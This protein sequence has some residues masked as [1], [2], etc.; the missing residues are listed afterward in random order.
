MKEKSGNAYRKKAAI[1]I[2]AVFAL[3]AVGL[4][5]WGV[6]LRAELTEVKGENSK[7]SM[8]LGELDD[9]KRRLE[10]ELEEST[11]LAQIEDY[12]RY[13]LGMQPP[14]SGQ[15]VPIDTAGEDH[16]ELIS[17]SDDS[18]PDETTEDWISSL[19]EYFGLG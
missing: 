19:P 10:I 3:T 7:L 17:D 11:D 14:E 13:V 2:F 4:L 18:E 15:I 6:L 5:V 16:G 9:E 12:A 1:C 8:Q